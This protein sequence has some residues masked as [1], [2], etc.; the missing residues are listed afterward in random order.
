LGRRSAIAATAACHNSLAMHLE[1]DQ[2]PPLPLVR[3]ER[4]YLR[5]AERSDIQ[6]F[7]R[8]FN[9]AELTS[10]LSMRAPMSEPMEEAWFNHMV[11][12]QG[13]DAYHF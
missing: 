3:G 9:D 2:P 5:A 13:K 10:F 11:E 7:V 1:T 6:I 12:Q 8:W 4:V